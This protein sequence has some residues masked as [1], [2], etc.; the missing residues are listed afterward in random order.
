[1]SE[2]SRQSKASFEPRLRLGAEL[3][4]IAEQLRAL[5]RAQDE[6]H[7]LYEAVLSREVEL[8]VVWS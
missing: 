8:S 1:M 7:D 5:A 3:E 4:R 6:L 2:D